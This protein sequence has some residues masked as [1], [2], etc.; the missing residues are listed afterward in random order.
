MNPG[1][2]DGWMLCLTD[3]WTEVLM[4]QQNEWMIG[5]WMEG[6]MDAGTKSEGWMDGWM[7]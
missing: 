5:G 2:M 6:W 4:D 7:H 3:R 1:M